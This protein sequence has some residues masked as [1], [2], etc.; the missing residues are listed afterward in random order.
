MAS[1][2]D[3]FR[4]VFTDRFSFLKILVFTIPIYYSYQLYL[5]SSADFTL[6][7]WATGLTLFFLFGF[8]TKITH[9]VINDGESVLP[10]LNPLKLALTSIKAFAAIAPAAIFFGWLANYVCSFINIVQWG[11]LILKTLIWLVVASVIVTSF[12]MFTTKERIIDAFKIKVLF[13]K[14]GDL[15]VALIVF[16]AQFALIN[17]LII[18]FIGY[19]IFI[20]FGVGLIL[21]FF[22]AFALVFNII[23]IGQYMAQIHYEVFDFK[24]SS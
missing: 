20:L 2:I 10:S 15:I 7:F 3:S 12:L 22:L 8:L 14:T 21:N 19:T 16:A 18:G 5:T 17:I 13:Q 1:I 24:S 9:N 11:G 6:L 23:A 4:D